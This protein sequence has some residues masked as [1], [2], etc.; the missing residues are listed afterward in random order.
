MDLPYNNT[1]KTLLFVGYIC[2]WFKTFLLTSLLLGFKAHANSNLLPELGDEASGYISLKEE[3]EIGK[4][5]L[6]QL[7]KQTVAVDEPLINEYLE[8]LMYRLIPHANLPQKEFDFIILDNPNLNAFAVPGGIIGVNLGLFLFAQDEDELASVMAHELAHL[9]QRHFARQMQEAEKQKPLAIAGIL[10]SI[11]LIATNNGDAGFAGLMSSQAASLQNRLRYSRVLER[12]ADRVGMKTLAKAGMDPFAMPSMFTHM[13]YRYR[14]SQRPPEFLLTHPISGN[15][16]ADAKGRAEN[17]KKQPRTQS[18]EFL[19][20]KHL[21]EIKYTYKNKAAIEHFL[22]IKKEKKAKETLIADAASYSL[23]YLYLQQKEYKKAL[24]QL[25]SIS[26]KLKQNSSVLS[27]KA[28]VLFA[29]NE[30]KK[31]FELLEK[32]IKNRPN[33]RQI[34]HTLSQLYIQTKQPEKAIP[35]LKGL[36]KKYNNPYSWQKISQAYQVNKQPIESLR[37]HAEYLYLTGEQINALRQLKLAIDMAKKKGDFQL[38]AVMERR[39]LSMQNSR[40]QLF[41]K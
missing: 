6:R 2:F 41:S 28:K 8:G 7:R 16:V 23:A 9:G 20:I 14:Y 19:L 30:Q 13:M 33:D 39:L 15:R 4:L 37:S 10:A 12:E 21:A 32:Q 24:L 22:T 11:L 34:A 27:L 1:K 3:R 26:S 17:L 5:W 18:F 35:H 38:Q 29:K 36:L 40:Q 31:A 25:A